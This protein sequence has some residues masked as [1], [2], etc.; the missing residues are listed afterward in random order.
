MC[1]QRG[2]SQVTE[3]LSFKIR[4]FRLNFM[5]GSNARKFV[6]ESVRKE[7]ATLLECIGMTLQEHNAGNASHRAATERRG[8][9]A[10]D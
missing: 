2:N 7:Q 4:E 9:A 6:A 1:N 8:I 10:A 5:T 3:M